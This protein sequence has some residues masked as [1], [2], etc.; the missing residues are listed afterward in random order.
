[1]SNCP[2]GCTLRGEWYCCNLCDYGHV[3]KVSIMNHI[4]AHKNCPSG[5]TIIDQERHQD[6]DWGYKCHRCNACLD[7]SIQ[8]TI[9]HDKFHEA[10]PEAFHVD[11]RGTRYQCDKCEWMSDAI[12]NCI[13]HAERHATLP[14]NFSLCDVHIGY[15]TH[16]NEYNCDICKEFTT[17]SL[18]ACGLHS[19][20][21]DSCPENFEYIKGLYKCAFCDS[22]FGSEADCTPHE[23]HPPE[24]WVKPIW[25]K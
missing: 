24:T 15:S 18:I 4:E 20:R 13:E 6:P 9:I 21:H 3:N 11:K 5:Y 25:W 2:D 8:C 16:H 14:K 17:S 23:S 19:K 10:C 1:M 22:W 12:Y 7:H